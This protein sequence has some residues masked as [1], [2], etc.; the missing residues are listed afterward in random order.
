MSFPQSEKC[1]HNACPIDFDTAS[2][3]WLSNKKRAGHSM[4]YTCTSL[5]KNG[6]QCGKRVHINEPTFHE[7]ALTCWQHM[8]KVVKRV[9]KNKK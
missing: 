6:K 4:V 1:A 3:A 7:G 9:K 2:A 8:K 5:C